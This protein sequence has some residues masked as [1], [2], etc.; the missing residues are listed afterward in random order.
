MASFGKILCL[1]F[2][3][4]MF[5]QIIWIYI[6]IRELS[7]TYRYMRA[8]DKRH[9]IRYDGHQF[10]KVDLNKR[11]QAVLNELTLNHGKC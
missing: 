10:W 5:M 1:L 8:I 6:G 7:D 2:F 3:A 11:S 4:V 9:P